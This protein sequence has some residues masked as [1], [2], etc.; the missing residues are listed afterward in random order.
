MYKFKI[1]WRQSTLLKRYK[2]Q[3]KWLPYMF[4]N[5]N[6]I[7]SCRLVAVGIRWKTSSSQIFV[8]FIKCFVL[9]G[10]NRFLKSYVVA[11]LYDITFSIYIF[12]P[13]RVAVRCLFFSFLQ[14][15]FWKSNFIHFF[16]YAIFFN[17]YSRIIDDLPLP[18]LHELFRSF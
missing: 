17:I 3:S 5:L 7:I 2:E 4:C 16:W 9:F 1:C 18:I 11:F 10:A 6:L 13:L 14:T 15:S 12:D 8:I